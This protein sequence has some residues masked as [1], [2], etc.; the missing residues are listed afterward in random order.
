MRKLGTLFQGKM[1]CGVFKCFCINGTPFN[2]RKAYCRVPL[3]EAEIVVEFCTNRI[4][5]GSYFRYDFV[6]HHHFL[7]IV[8]R[9]DRWWAG[10]ALLV[11][12]F[13]ETFLNR[14]VTV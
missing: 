14:R 4:F 9:V 8:P 13:G 6:T 5:D 1:Q 10:Q 12:K 7:L 11:E 2:S 3:S